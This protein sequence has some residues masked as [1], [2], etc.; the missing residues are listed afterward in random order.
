MGKKRVPISLRKPPSPEA[1]ES[2]VQAGAAPA[3]APASEEVAP[4]IA[5]PAAHVAEPAARVV[6][7]AASAAEPAARVI[8]PEQVARVAEPEPPAV[9]TV[10]P[11]PAPAREPAVF[12]MPREPERPSMLI[13]EDGQALRPITVYLPLPLTEQLG[14]HCLELD[15]NLNRVVGDALEGYLDRRLGPGAP[16]RDDVRARAPRASHATGSFWAD[17]VRTVID[18]ASAHPRAQR[19]IDLGRSL[20][21]RFQPA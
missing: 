3:E 10:M 21:G 12:V 5:E 20:F 13:G 4:R 15:R 16:R 1:L 9:L 19:F 11:E 8:E 7:P 18:Q 14:R 6:E 17:M 2:F